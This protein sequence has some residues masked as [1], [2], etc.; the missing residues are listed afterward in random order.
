M[1]YV[2]TLQSVELG[3]LGRSVVPANTLV[4]LLW[5]TQPQCTAAKAVH[6]H[7]SRPERVFGGVAGGPPDSDPA[8]ERAPWG[9]A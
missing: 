6:T 5:G 1:A 3:V 7:I 8:R 2:T 4:E 9:V